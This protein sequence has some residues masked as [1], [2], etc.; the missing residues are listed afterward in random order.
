MLCWQQIFFVGVVAFQAT[1]TC[2]R[3]VLRSSADPDDLDEEFKK[4]LSGEIKPRPKRQVDRAKRRYQ[5]A[6]TQ[7][8]FQQ[9]WLKRDTKFYLGVIAAISFVPLILIALSTQT[10]SPIA[11]SPYIV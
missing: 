4:V 7:Q 8:N 1:P 10:T 6:R 11:E 5:S 3:T 9:D 2:R